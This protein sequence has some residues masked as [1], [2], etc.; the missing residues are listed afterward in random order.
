M[1]WARIALAVFLAAALAQGC[2]NDKMTTPLHT[3]AVAVFEVQPATLALEEGQ[4]YTLSATATCSCGEKLDV[5]IVWRSADPAVAT[6]D[7]TGVV[8][9]VLEG[10]TAITAETDSPEGAKVA[11]TAL[12][13]SRDGVEVEPTGGTVS[14]EAGAVVLE[15]PDGALNGKTTITIRPS[16]GE[17]VAERPDLIGGT[18]Y[19]F[20]P[21]GLQFQKQARLTIRYEPTSLPAGVDPARLR[22]FHR[23]QTGWVELTES[24]VDPATRKVS[25]PIEGF[26]HYG[27]AESGRVAVD[28]VVVQGAPAEPLMIGTTVQLTA[29]V[30][31]ASGNALDGRGVSWRSSD[32]AVASVDQ[33]G[34]VAGVSHGTVSVTA[35]AEGVSG[36]ASIMVRGEPTAGLGNNLSYP[37]IFAEGY[38][39]AGTD[40][41]EEDG[42]RPGPEEGI[43][44]EQRPFFYQGNKT[45]YGSYYLQQGQNVW[46]AAWSDGRTA[47]W[48]HRVVVAWGDNL[49]QRSWNTH[50][51]IRVENTLYADGAAPM[52]GFV[53]TY[54]YGEG[55][56][57]MQGTDGS[58]YEAVP[59]VFSVL[60]R[61]TI[62][63]LSGEDPNGD[64]GAPVC[65]V[66]DG[67]IHE[68]AGTEGPGKYSA[69]VNVAGK[70]IYGFNL[71]IR[72]V[73][74]CS[75]DLHRY[76]WW[77]LT[78]RLDDQ[79]TVGGT[80]VQRGM[81]LAGIV[82]GEG[83]GEGLTYTPRFDPATQTS[84]IDIY[85]VSAR[86]GGG[87]DDHTGG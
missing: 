53:M 41:T 15:I 39:P 64:P 24:Q 40:V 6:V 87:G 60:P 26:S 75:T 86:G 74:M 35:T 27:V 48:P 52:Q 7:S 32:E 5:P 14:Y 79:G 56:S 11:T 69:E 57:E 31:D 73:T 81:D 17:V 45:D 62:E 43:V 67:A 84:W 34:L 9:A 58:L 47:T 83:G 2:G 72:D 8:T 12:A 4:T 22:L 51:P 55:P 66:Y 78:F 10:K 82:F 37:T 68:N 61:L 36:S 49:T 30:Y 85:V 21:D 23:T 59:T 13:V 25:G 44:V 29:A 65:T 63:K 50:S 76:G 3:H 46:Q 38:G 42:L 1:K 70:I 16:P 80:T 71:T 54:L 20:R 77:R 19:Q 18:A 28:R 33:T